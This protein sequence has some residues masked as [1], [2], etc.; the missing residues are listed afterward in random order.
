MS[1]EKSSAFRKESLNQLKSLR[2][3][4]I[5]MF[6]NES[7]K[8]NY[9]IVLRPDSESL[10]HISSLI[11]ELREVS[12]EQYYYPLKNLHLTVIGNIPIEVDEHKL[13]QAVENA[14]SGYELGFNLLGLGSNQFCSSI[15]AYPHDFSIHELRDKIRLVADVKGDD[16]SSILDSYEYVGWI[17]YLRYLTYPS[18]MFL[19][20]LYEYRNTEFGYLRPQ[21]AQLFKNTSKVLDSKS[22][23]LI[24]E[25]QL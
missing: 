15:S 24:K 4:Q 10:K 23:E 5:R 7:I 6:D 21:I 16:Y 12:P 8:E 11:E 25:W 19:D 2:P 17:N 22:A 20:R 14:L 1:N 13:T 9:T 18:Q 3:E